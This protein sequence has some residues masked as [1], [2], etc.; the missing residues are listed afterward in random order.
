MCTGLVNGP[1]LKFL[2]TQELKEC[3]YSELSLQDIAD[4]LS[5]VDFVDNVFVYK[6]GND[7]SEVTQATR[8]VLKSFYLNSLN[9][10]Q[11][12]IQ[13]GAEIV[14]QV[15]EENGECR[16]ENF[17]AEARYSVIYSE[18]EESF[19]SQSLFQID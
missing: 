6:N 5:Y 17:V 13:E 9:N 10:Q 16:V 7:H 18:K 14:T 4:Q 15:V 2:K 8:G 11:I 12:D 19:D 1:P 3:G